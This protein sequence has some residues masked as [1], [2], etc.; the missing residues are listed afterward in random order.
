M[1]YS[2]QHYQINHRIDAPI[3][4]VGL[5]LDEAIPAFLVIGL[6][7]YFNAQLLSIMMAACYV[8]IIK[9][10]KKGQGTHFLLA[11]LYWHVDAVISR[12]GLRLTP[13]ASLRFWL[14]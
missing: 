11:L 13:P 4:L 12:M 9:R 14:K 8:G 1:S 3:R 6:G 5:T 10:L 7:F 2:S